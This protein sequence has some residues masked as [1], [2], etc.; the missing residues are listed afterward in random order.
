MSIGSDALKKFLLLT[1]SAVMLFNSAG[2]AKKDDS[3]DSSLY[4]E[5]SAVIS[6]PSAEDLTNEDESP[7]GVLSLTELDTEVNSWGQGTD[8]DEENRPISCLDFQGKYGEYGGMFIAGNA[9]K[10]IYLTIDQGYEN[11]YTEK[12]LDVLKEKDVSV[13]FFITNNYISKNHDLV[14]RMIDEGHTIGNHSYNHPNMPTLSIEEQQ[15]EITMLHDYVANE[16]SYEMTLFRP[17]EGTFSQQSLAVAQA[18]GYKSVFWSYA[19]KDWDPD[20]QMQPSEALEK[21]KSH[22]HNGA[23]Y[24]L[25]NTGST[26]VEIMGEFID[27]IR[28]E[29]YSF[30]LLK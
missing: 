10:E 21:L 26:N 15:E 7:V 30:G 5:E 23:I 20:D 24:L 2:C 3:T 25:H 29:G 28:S 17:P 19:Y 27:S 4:V 16:F 22:A 8:V 13:V 6:E 12:M 14:Q 11:G 18:L 9:D 1:V